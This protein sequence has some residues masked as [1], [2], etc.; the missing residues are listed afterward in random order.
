MKVRLD[1][2]PSWPKQSVV[3]E[4][5]PMRNKFLFCVFVLNEVH[6]NT[7]QNLIL[8]FH[9]A[10]FQAFEKAFFG[11]LRG[12]FPVPVLWRIGTMSDNN[13][14]LRDVRIVERKLQNLVLCSRAD[15]LNE[16]T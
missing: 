2:L 3:D 12:L 1:V 11:H 13:S 4:I 7:V 14:E 10:V 8:V 6:F 16:K 15:N 9:C 5:V